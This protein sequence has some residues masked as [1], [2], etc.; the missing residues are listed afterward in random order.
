MEP[1]LIERESRCS[2]GAVVGTRPGSAQRWKLRRASPEWCAV[3]HGVQWSQRTDCASCGVQIRELSIRVLH[4]A[5]GTHRD[6]I[7]VDVASSGS[8]LVRV[9]SGTC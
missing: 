2:A 5:F 6:A 4:I 8:E 9:G 1:Q 7:M 3:S